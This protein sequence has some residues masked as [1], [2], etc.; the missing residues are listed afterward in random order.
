MK[1]P[2]QRG[3][4]TARDESYQREQLTVSF[5]ILSVILSASISSYVTCLVHYSLQEG[6]DL[7]S[8]LGYPVQVRSGQ[9]VLTISFLVVAL[10]FGCQQ[11]NTQTLTDALD[12]DNR[13]RV[14]KN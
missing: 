9:Q 5:I 2:G 4:V 8:V 14:N 13:S 10:V 1:W 6:C 3:G 12:L 7:L 11:F